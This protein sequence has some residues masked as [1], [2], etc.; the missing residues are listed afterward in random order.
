MAR[1][2]ARALRA[3]AARDAVVA[4]EGVERAALAARVLAA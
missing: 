3:R 1:R 2:R 4:A